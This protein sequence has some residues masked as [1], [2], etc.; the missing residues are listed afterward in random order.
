[1][2][3]FEVTGEKYTIADDKVV[4]G[5]VDVVRAASESAAIE[6]FLTTHTA[7]SPLVAWRVTS[8]QRR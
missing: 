1:M 2:A 7:P 8:V 3:Q 5:D 6:T 4:G